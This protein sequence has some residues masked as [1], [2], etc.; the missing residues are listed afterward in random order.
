[1]SN[2]GAIDRLARARSAEWEELS[3]LVDEAQGRP[4]RLS[5]EKLRRLGLLYRRAA[6]DLAQARRI[7]PTDPVSQRVETIV[8]G[9]RSVVYASRARQSTVVSFLSRDYWR[10]VRQRARFSWIAAALL[11]VPAIVMFVWALDDPVRAGGVVGVDVTQF[12][13]SAGDFRGTASEDSSIGAQIFINNIR[14]SIMAFALGVSF[15][16]GTVLVLVFNGA[17]LGAVTGA[18]FAAGNGDVVTALVIPHGILELSI[19]IVASAV[20]LSMAGALVDPGIR[21]R[22][23]AVVEQAQAGALI[24]L[25]TM[26]WFV[27]AGLVESFVTPAGLGVGAAIVIGVALGA[28]YWGL[29][30]WRGAPGV[31]A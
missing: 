2:G 22:G 18:A 5:A 7:A 3:R 29:V 4:K 16:V 17:L 30:W 28:I 26:P 14:V 11:I 12:R 25:G 24:V 6:A 20:G 9:A 1:M 19:I 15:G 23:P 8:N 21:R 31:S 10:L 13:S 27:L